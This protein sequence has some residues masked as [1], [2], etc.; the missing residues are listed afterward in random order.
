M[1]TVRGPTRS[2]K[3]PTMSWPREAIANTRNASCPSVVAETAI[4][5]RRSS[6]T[7]GSAN[8]VDWKT[9]LETAVVRKTMA[10]TSKEQ[11][12]EVGRQHLDGRG[13]LLAHLRRDDLGPH[14]HSVADADQ[15]RDDAWHDERGTPSAVVDEV[16]RDQRG[17]GDAQVAPHAVDGNAHARVAPLLHHDGESDGMIDGGKDAEDEK[18]SAD[19]KRRAGE[20]GGNGCTAD[21][22]KVGAH[23]AVAA[24]LV[25]KPAGRQRE[26]AECDEAGRGVSEQVGVAEAPIA[27]QRQRRHR[28][29]DQHEEM[30]EEVADV[31]QQKVQALAHMR[32]PW[33]G[34]DRLFQPSG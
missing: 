22:D 15:D 1:N 31:E 33:A 17:T 26:H 13:R 28:G 14:Q 19:L 18:A 24:P 8:V 25:G 20:G 12:L 34:V 9:M 3:C 23:H 4:P 2:R 6:K 32:A 10:E 27:V 21:A 5:C 16:A 11:R 30:I 7:L 29:E